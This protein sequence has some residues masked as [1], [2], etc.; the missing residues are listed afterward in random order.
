MRRFLSNATDTPRIQH[1]EPEVLRP[2][3][4]RMNDKHFEMLLLLQA[5]SNRFCNLSFAIN[6]DLII[7]MLTNRITK[8]V[9]G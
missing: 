3:R 4:C 7:V 6:N 1:P 9:N 2:K 8:S 5:N